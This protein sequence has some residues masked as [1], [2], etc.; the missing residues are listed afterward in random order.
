MSLRKNI[1]SKSVQYVQCVLLRLLLYA[2]H[3]LNFSSLLSE[4]L[5]L[6]ISYILLKREFVIRTDFT[7]DFNCI[8]LNLYISSGG[9]RSVLIQQES[10]ISGWHT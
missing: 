2:G 10:I 3:E 4:N 1:F 8:F 9:R 6:F 7:M 5:K